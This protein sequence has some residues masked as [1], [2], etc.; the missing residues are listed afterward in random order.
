MAISVSRPVMPT[1]LLLTVAGICSA[2]AEPTKIAIYDFELNDFSAGGGIIAPDARDA[3]YLAEATAEAKRLLGQS[4]RYALTE[5]A[6]VGD[7]GPVKEHQ[8]R[9]CGDCIGTLTRR[10]GA[11]AGV[12][13]T[14]TRINRTEYTLLI[15][16]FEPGSGSPVASYY[17][18]LRMGANYA[19]ARGVT[20]L[21]RNRILAGPEARR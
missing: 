17:T 11:D 4:G 15:Q 2:R 9:N 19:W 14:I 10:L 1:A 12:L 7:E 18:G 16:F 20:W 13:G 3:R 6:P 21:I 8:M 5:T